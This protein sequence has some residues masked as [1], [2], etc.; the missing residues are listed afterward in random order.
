[1][2]VKTSKRVSLLLVTVMLVTSLL[3]PF[4][5]SVIQAESGTKEEIAVL[6]FA[7]SANT[8]EGVLAIP[9]TMPYHNEELG[10]TIDTNAAYAKS[11]N[12]LLRATKWE[13]G[14]YWSFGF[15]TTGYDNFSIQ[16]NQRS[17]GT[18]PRDFK[19]QYSLDNNTW[20]DAQGGSYSVTDSNSA[21]YSFDLTLGLSGD[22]LYLRMITTSDISCRAGTGT[23]SPTEKIQTGGVNNI[24]NLTL[25]GIRL[26]GY[27]PVKVEPVTANYESNS[28]VDK[29]AFIELYS[30]TVVTGGA[31]ITGGAIRYAVNS[32]S[33]ET[34]SEPFTL[35]E[36]GADNG[37]TDFTIETYAELNG[38]KS[39]YSTYY[40]YTKEKELPGAV[41]DPIPQELADSLGAATI[42]TVYNLPKNT[43]VTVVG[44][45]AFKYGNVYNGA[46]SINTVLL[47]DVIDGEIIGLQVYDTGNVYT[48]GDIVTVTG[49]V[50]DYNSVRQLSG[51]TEVKVAAKA[52]PFKPQVKTIAELKAGGDS[53]L[54]EYILIKN[55]VIGVY[56]SSGNTTITDATGSINLFKGALPPEGLKE[57]DTVSLYAAWSKYNTNYQL[58]NGATSDYVV[59][60]KDGYSLDTTLNL[61]AASFA[62]TGELPGAVVYGDKYTANDYLDTSINL[63][64]SSG[65]KPQLTTTSGGVTSYFLGT[66]GSRAGSYYQI[67]LS[68][69]YYGNLQL[70]YSMKGSNTG[71]KNFNV[72]YSTDGNTW[73]QTNAAPFS[74]TGA[75]KWENITVSLP[76]GVNHQESTYIRLQVA[77]DI[78]INNGTIGSSGT[79]YLSEVTVTGNPVVS[80]SI[81]GYPVISPGSEQIRQGEA[82]TLTSSTEG[83]ELYYSF[84]G[85]NY[86]R[87]DNNDKPV[88]TELPVTVTAYGTKDGLRNSLSIIKTYT[89]AQTASVKADPNGGARTLGTKVT[90]TTA[91]EGA[92]ILYSLD[93]GSNWLTY[94]KDNKISLD[95]LPMVITA[96]AIK[97]GF[98]DSE[99][100]TFSYTQR[101]NEEYNLYFGQLH[102]HTDFSDGAGTCDQ[103]FEYA[104]N[105]A[106][107]IDFLAVTDHSNS[108][109]NAA[110]ATISDGSMSTEWVEGHRLSEEYTDASF[111][112]IYGY[113]MTWSNGLG[114][115]N[116]FNT[117]GFQSRTQ[118][119]YSTYSTAL[120]NYYTT[121]KTETG[122]ISQ[123]NHPGTTFGDFSDFAHYDKE[124]DDLITLIEVGNGE[125]AIGSSGYFPSYEYYTRAL[126][127]GWHVAP[128]NNQDNHKGY[129]GDSNT[130]RTVVLA[131]SLTQENVYDAMR[132]MRVY[133]TEDND[134][135]IQYTLNDEIMGTILDTTPDSVNI[136]V[137]VKD[138]TDAAIG[139][140][141]V[142]VNG[143]LSI[144]QETVSTNQG[145]VEFNLPADYS[146]YYIRITQPDKNI[147]VTAPVWIKEVEAVGISSMNTTAVLPVKGEALPINTDIFNNE[148]EDFIID[149]MEYTVNNQV[150]HSVDLEKAGLTKLAAYQTGTYSFSYMYPD[151]GTVNIHVTLKGSLAGIPKVY[152]SVLKLTFAD[153][154]MVTNVV[155]DGTHYND[156]V[157]GYYGGNM[158][159]F[160]EIAAGENIKVNIVKDKLTK[161]ILDA[162]D[163]LIVSAPAKKSGTANAG[164]YETSHFETEFVELVTEYVNSGGTLV[165]CGLAD[166]QDTLEGQSS[167]EINKIL[168]SIGATTRLNSD[169]AVDDSN[170][171][172]QNYRL[173]LTDFNK[174]SVY[175][176]GIEEGQVYSAYSGSTV[177]LDET[178]IL[179]GRAEY[180]VKGHPTTYSI[181]SKTFG[182][183]YTAVDKGEVVSLAKETLAGGSNV[184][185][186]GT[187]FMSDFEVKVELDN[188]WDL[189]Y[190]NKTILLN[191]LHSIKKEMPVSS[192]AE[193]RKGTKGE[194]YSGEGIVTAGTASGNAFFDTIYIED[195]TGGINIFPINEGLIELGQRVK[196]TGYLD[197][198]LGDLELRVITAEVTDTAKNPKEPLAVTSK[199]A[200][201]YDKNGG[202][203]V[204][205]QGKV[206]DVIRK[207][208][209]VETIF[210]RDSS[211]V[212]ARVFIDGY[213][214]YSKEGS[215]AL[216]AIAKT[217]NELSAVGLVSFDT[218]GERLRVRDRSE[219]ILIKDSA[220]PGSETDGDTDYNDSN[221][222]SVSVERDIKNNLQILTTVTKTIDAFGNTIIA[223]VITKSDLTSGSTKEIR[224]ETET[225]NEAAGTKVLAV[226]VYDSKM[227]L[228]KAEAY[229]ELGSQTQRKDKESIIKAV[230]PETALTTALLNATKEVPLEI[231]FHLPQKEALKQIKEQAVKGI[232]IQVSLPETILKSDQVNLNVINL[233]KEIIQAAKQEGKTVT[234][235][236]IE[237]GKTA[238]SW[239]LNGANLK[240]SKQKITDINAAL[241]ILPLE[242]ASSIHQPIK[243]YLT[244]EAGKNGLS[245]N[246]L[247]NGI[248][249]GITEV[250][251]Y[252]GNQESYKT[253]QKVYIYYFN[254]NAKYGTKR[255]N[256]SRLEE[257][258]TVEA[259]IDKNGYVTVEINH[260]SSYVI[261]PEKPNKAIV[262]LLIEQVQVPTSKTLTM[263]NAVYMGIKLPLDAKL[264]EITYTTSNPK[265]AVVNKKGLITPKKSGAVTITTTIRINGVTK[266]YKTKLIIKK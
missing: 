70:S 265:I 248:L 1:M 111:V 253:G 203:L 15:R 120:S 201:D 107:Q 232:E 77:D 24:G 161:E 224:Y 198:Y 153:P 162:C 12:N 90:L 8:E 196:V 231:T 79:N 228:I 93:G 240:A 132:N 262:A 31:I 46:N 17:S 69:I 98:K 189:P 38:I 144:A 261:L 116:T 190:A 89:Q 192:I 151:A 226:R 80:D 126:D 222:T 169:E 75:N 125:G 67:E 72:L 32:G 108:F 170:N 55:A 221:N 112:G 6:T 245:V 86:S 180:L 168:T 244:E 209:I 214:Q 26:E 146:Y 259:V 186:A 104:K 91:T 159:N 42:D 215:Q 250:T 84:D 212:T 23:Y 9:D 252:V 213:I 148:T 82:L 53:Y 54:S 121:L 256:L 225:M 51:I 199:D 216:E 217:G 85:T 234:L 102:S 109:D 62:G 171:G 166:Y 154:N 173:Y 210:I 255:K 94:D 202:R 188:I 174:N 135:E 141:E 243:T 195:E 39:T 28:V 3:S 19:L 246:F 40:Y 264:P 30:P 147:A 10:S 230:V 220:K 191:V 127:K 78:S 236:V 87:Y 64:H 58:R 235:T 163:L 165:L 43:S 178:A 167:T 5:Q 242:K 113:E 71:P 137:K 27:E 29:N 139:K 251:M 157:S 124:I 56:N 238:Y 45:V 143:G 158:G 61:E 254:E 233:Q 136:K 22:W 156:Y 7:P 223:K 2:H 16:Y 96:K 66:K 160:S 155:V 105:I 73:T 57:G 193:I 205:I 21:V 103:A 208:N 11:T 140:I 20:I 145:T 63:T 263:N 227:T 68:T 59:T 204:K 241:K 184:F 260:C 187:V 44:Q 177:L 13:V 49:I 92:E 60:G 179:E 247:H 197:E 81:V 14:D 74:I 65:E 138:P 123:F 152:Q 194:I 48:V 25:S 176:E 249:P 128:T 150:I 181:D 101:L 47:Q 175:N 219:I 37:N 118:S 142:I 95:K 229:V 130:A 33:F 182:E 110:A 129:W 18:G 34:Y 206:T 4:H 99:S 97:S 183:G 35:S 50:G 172:G 117:P 207:N 36:Y 239:K 185:V 133:A 211:G 52:E 149:S 200:M 164:N 266:T 134:L 119:Q 257:G 83:A 41:T 76:S 237:K 122:S 88:L 218:E 114:H 106:E 258:S 131:D 100:S 115:I